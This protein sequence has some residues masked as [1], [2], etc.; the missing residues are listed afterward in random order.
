VGG[1]GMDDRGSVLDN[2]RNFSLR[3]H[4]QSSSEGY[5]ASYKVGTGGSFPWL[6]C[7]EREA[8]HSSSSSAEALPPLHL[9]ALMAWCLR[10]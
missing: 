3:Q 5:L 7:R 6:K 2:G 10:T 9:Y 1:C 4:V 8:D